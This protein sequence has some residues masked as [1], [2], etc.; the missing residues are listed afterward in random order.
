MRQRFVPFNVLPAALLLACVP[1]LAEDL[2][3][4]Q[5]QFLNLSTVEKRV[6][7]RLDLAAG[8]RLWPARIVAAGGTVWEVPRPSDK[9]RWTTVVPSIYVP[10][11]DYSLVL[12]G[13]H[14]WGVGCVNQSIRT[15]GGSGCAANCSSTAAMDPA[16]V[17]MP[18][19][20][21]EGQL[22]E[23]KA[24]P[25]VAAPNPAVEW[26]GSGC[27]YRISNPS[28]YGAVEICLANT[29]ARHGTAAIPVCRSIR[30]SL[31]A[32]VEGRQAVA[33]S[34]P[35]TTAVQAPGVEEPAWLTVTSTPPGATIRVNDNF[36]GKTPSK[37]KL[38]A[39]DYTIAIE[40]PGFTTWKRSL[41]LVSGSA[42]SVD[43]QL[44]AAAPAPA[45]PPPAPPPRGKPAAR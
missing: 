31:R 19:K 41:K 26:A 1:V 13:T 38:A 3:F 20:A 14:P 9:V 42:I 23:I 27:L 16:E 45:E 5:G 4:P 24:Q 36:F 39:G 25:V 35:I 7:A 29:S 18:W 32:I 37:I 8:L 15:G 43:A 40:S 44:G 22:Y 17:G 28:G 11:G 34:A 10:A 33:A 12:A 30:Y 2:V 6:Y 21:V